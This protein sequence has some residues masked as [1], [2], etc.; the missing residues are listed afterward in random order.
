MSGEDVRAGA[1]GIAVGDGDG[2]AEEES[3]ESKY[4]PD[5]CARRGSDWT[6]RVDGERAAV[7]TGAYVWRC[8]RCGHVDMRAGANHRRVTSSNR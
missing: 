8:E 4:R 7:K 3:V 2:V 6:E 5:E 1:E